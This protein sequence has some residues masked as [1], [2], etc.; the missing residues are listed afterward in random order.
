M[1]SGA[2]PVTPTVGAEG[3]GTGKGAQLLVSEVPQWGPGVP[4]GVSAKEGWRRESL[5]GRALWAQEGIRVSENYLA[6]EAATS[7]ERF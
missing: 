6:L 4:M 1:G 7:Q 5:L 3:L 2:D